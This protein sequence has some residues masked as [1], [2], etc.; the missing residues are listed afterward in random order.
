VTRLR[1]G[2]PRNRGSISSRAK[3][4]FFSKTSNPALG[5]FKH[6]IQWISGADH[7]TASGAGVNNDVK[8]KLSAP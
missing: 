2:Q 3:P 6:R 7:L 5:Y 1:T 4:L 8:V